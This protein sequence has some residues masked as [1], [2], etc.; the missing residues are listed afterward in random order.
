MY[1]VDANHFPT[2]A[3][4]PPSAGSHLHSYSS[5]G[6]HPAALVVPPNV[7]GHEPT[8]AGRRTIHLET[9][10]GLKVWKEKSPPNAYHRHSTP[11]ATCQEAPVHDSA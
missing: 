7:L 8:V 11:I 2:N 9:D 6:T 4:V 1:K 3:H 5:R 10:A